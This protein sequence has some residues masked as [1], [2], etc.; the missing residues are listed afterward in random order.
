M[1]VVGIICEY[2][3]FHFGHK[4]QIEEAKRLTGSEY[5]VAVMSGNFVQRGEP[6][7]MSKSSRVKTALEE[8]ADI[9]LEL[10]LTYACSSAQFFAQGAVS[11]L[12]SSG[13]VTHLSFGS[14]SGDLSKIVD[15]A[16]NFESKQ[17]SIKEELSRGASYAKAVESLTGIAKGDS[18]DILAVEYIRALKKYSSDMIPLPVKR[19]SELS[20]GEK[21]Y[22]AA[23]IRNAILKH[24]GEPKK[25]AAICGKFLPSFSSKNALEELS[26]GRFPV[27]LENFSQVFFAKL[28]SGGPDFIKNLPGVSEGLENKLY[29]ASLDSTSLEE[30]ISSCVSKRYTAS[31]IKRILVHAL[32]CGGNF[33]GYDQRRPVPYIR[34]LGMRK[35]ASKLSEMI[36]EKS[37]VPYV[38]SNADAYKICPEL[39]RSEA[40]AND[41]YSVCFP[42]GTAKGRREYTDKFT[43]I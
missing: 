8:G 20:S 18:N 12:S 40:A 38:M 43:V 26:A 33:Y 14:E 22:S 16:D 3:P 31:R 10:P 7:L 13:V 35:E 6:A 29:D 36:A 23:E 39:A 11:V 42:C 24:S 21:I 27:C 34:V 9:V 28:R 30:L 5:A 2:N 19:V 37:S 4:Y 17:A 32:V 25:I 41:V 15:A 1:N